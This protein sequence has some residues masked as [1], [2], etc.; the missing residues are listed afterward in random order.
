MS[1]HNDISAI[2]QVAK[3]SIKALHDA[4]LTNKINCVGVVKQY[5]IYRHIIT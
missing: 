2:F 5:S 3:T 1:G 4:I